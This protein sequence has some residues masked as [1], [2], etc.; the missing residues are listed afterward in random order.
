MTSTFFLNAKNGPG[1][2]ALLRSLNRS[3]LYRVR[4]D[5]YDQRTLD[6]NAKQ[7]AMLADIAKQCMHLN[8]KLDED[9]WKRLAVA[10]FR[11]DSIASNIP[12]V[13]DYWRKQKFELMPSLDG[14]TLVAIGAQ[15]RDFPK[16]VT[17]AFIDW[18]YHYGAEHDVVWSE[19]EKYHDQRMAA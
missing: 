8:R 4:I 13:A 5:E 1:L 12:K 18:L 14:H 10:Q 17:A 3:L 16:Y 15:T 11:D 9:S 19:P 2:M 6:Q 7:H